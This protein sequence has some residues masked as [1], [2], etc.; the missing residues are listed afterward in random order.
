MSAQWWLVPSLFSS[1]CLSPV[2]GVNRF[3]RGSSRRLCPVLLQH[4]QAQSLLAQSP[5][6]FP[7]FVWGGLVVLPLELPPVFCLEVSLLAFWVFSHHSENLMFHIKDNDIENN[8]RNFLL[9]KWN[10]SWNIMITHLSS[11]ISDSYVPFHRWYCSAGLKI[12]L[13]PF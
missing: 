6:L 8:C 10:N 4:L 9:S 12:S 3:W 13:W 5:E 1:P 7:N 11:Y 2:S